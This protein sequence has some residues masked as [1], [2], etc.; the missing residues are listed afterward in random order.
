MAIDD[1]FDFFRM[2]LETAHIDDPVA[3]AD[4][5]VAAPAEFEGIACIHK[6]LRIL[7]WAAVFTQVTKRRALRANSQGAILNLHLN[8]GSVLDYACRKAHGA[9]AHV[10]RDPGLG[11]R[12]SMGDARLRIDGSEMVQDCLVGNF[13]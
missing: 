12:E 11:G 8:P 9:V 2:D 5:V 7:E 3:P 13:A 4:E 6:A 1:C 10:E